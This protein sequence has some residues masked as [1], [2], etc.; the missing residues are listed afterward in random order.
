MRPKP[1]NAAGGL[2]CTLPRR[3][4]VKGICHLHLIQSLCAGDV[5]PTIPPLKTRALGKEPAL[6]PENSSRDECSLFCA[7]SVIITVGVSS[8]VSLF[9]DQPKPGPNLSLRQLSQQLYAYTANCYH[10]RLQLSPDVWVSDNIKEFVT[11]PR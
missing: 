7:F 3:C 8:S 1:F 10:A 6:L 9:M 2:F 4:D 5:T 11:V